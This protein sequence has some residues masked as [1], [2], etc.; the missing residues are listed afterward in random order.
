MSGDWAFCAHTGCEAH[1]PAA[2]TSCD[3][4]KGAEQREVRVTDR[5]GDIWAT[6]DGVWQIVGHSESHARLMDKFVQAA[7][8]QR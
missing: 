5:W 4:H 2:R 1:I 3:E 8:E 7:E 6:R